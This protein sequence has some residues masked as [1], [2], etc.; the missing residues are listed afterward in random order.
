MSV[1]YFPSRIIFDL[2]CSITCFESMWR[3]IHSHARKSNYTYIHTNT[4]IRP[5]DGVLHTE[6]KCSPQN[7][8]IDARFHTKNCLPDLK[9]DHSS[10]KNRQQTRFK[11][12]FGAKTVNI[13]RN[14]IAFSLVAIVDWELFFH[15]VFYRCCCMI[16]LKAK[17]KTVFGTFKTPSKST[18]VRSTAFASFFYCCLF[19]VFPLR[20]RTHSWLTLKRWKK[21]TGMC[22]RSYRW[23]VNLL[24]RCYKNPNDWWKMLSTRAN[25][26]HLNMHV[27][28]TVF[29]IYERAESMWSRI[30]K[31]CDL[32]KR[33]TTHTLANIWERGDET[34]KQLCNCRTFVFNFI[35]FVV[36]TKQ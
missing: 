6:E 25:L 1:N 36:F 10:A 32:F 4:K 11:F 13:K 26:Q 19:N 35:Q 21:T 29:R 20:T 34:I 31:H 5:N 17:K 12:K 3:D 16:L 2:K 14:T 27:L 15:F 9:I 24:S 23:H 8:I 22:V 28:F 33:E 18:N 7:I 30:G